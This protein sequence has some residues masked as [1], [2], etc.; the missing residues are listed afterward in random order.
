MSSGN[1]SS[2]G[3]SSNEDSSGGSLLRQTLMNVDECFL[4][5]LPPLA[6]SGGHRA[7]QWDL[8]NPLQTC[9]FQVERRDNDLYLLF[10]TENHTKLFALSKLGDM[11]T[12]SGGSKGIEGV[13][14]SS[15][16]F[17]TQIQNQ[18]SGTG[19]SRSVYVGFGFRDRDV[20]LDLLGNLQQFQKSIQREQQAKSMKVTEIPKLAEGEKI[21][22]SFGKVGGGGGDS[23]EK[24]SR[25]GG[26]GSAAG[27]MLLKKPPKVE[28]TPSCTINT[29]VVGEE[30]VEL[31]MEN[32]NLQDDHKSVA[33]TDSEGAHAANDDGDLGDNDD[34][35]D[36]EE[37]WDDFQQAG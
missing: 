6:T 36:D 25:S 33:S 3:N 26:G 30:Q 8:A 15:R 32:I 21:H 29:F 22:I 10:T 28:V 17:V 31:N 11:S 9:G 37:E 14:D 24:K 7:E 19:T 18:G 13:M 12:T 5:K 2:I 23:S 34:D 27:P 16:Y 20:A 1:S 4:Y 35:D